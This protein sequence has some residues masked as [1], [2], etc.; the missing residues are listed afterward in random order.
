MNEVEPNNT[1]R[2]QSFEI[3]YE[4][5]DAF[6]TKKYDVVWSAQK[7]NMKSDHKSGAFRKAADK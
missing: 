2:S 4:H 3:N 5:L 7:K 6:K 1:L